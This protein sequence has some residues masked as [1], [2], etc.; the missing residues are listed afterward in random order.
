MQN[1]LYVRVYCL[2]G[3]YALV[4]KILPAAEVN[5]S[6]NQQKNPNSYDANSHTNKNEY[7]FILGFVVC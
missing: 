4:R 3:R 2:K 7:Y 5:E 6:S 1:N